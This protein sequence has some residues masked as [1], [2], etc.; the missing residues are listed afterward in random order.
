[1]LL[2]HFQ[3]REQPFG[4]TPDPRFLYESRSHREALAS[5]Y[6]AFYG[7]RGF[8]ALIAPP[9]MGKTTL[10]FQFLEQIRES[11]RTVFLFDTQCEPRELIRYILR[12]LGIEPGSDVVEMHHQLH[13]VLTSEARAGS[14]SFWLSMKHRIC[15]KRLWRP[16]VC[17]PTSK[18]HDKS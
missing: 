4:T 14:A 6:C 11:A 3:F 16:S 7:N 8:T 2:Q 18:L 10:L 13:G 17:S 9:G 1:M 5:L 12:D 15:Q